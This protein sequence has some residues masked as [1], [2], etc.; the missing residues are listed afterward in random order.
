MGLLKNPRRELFA[1]ECAKGHSAAAAYRTAYNYE[2]DQADSLG[3]RL[4]GKVSSRIRELQEEASKD[5]VMS[6]IQKRKLLAIIMRDTSAK[7]SDRIA[8]ILAD[9]KLSG[10]L[11]DKIEHSG[12][13]DSEVTLTESARAELME[14]VRRARGLP[15]SGQN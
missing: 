15:P 1:Q 5:A 3:A 13:I 4:S 8:A 9:T 11:T 14:K 10:E 2:G 6:L 7:D 12:Q